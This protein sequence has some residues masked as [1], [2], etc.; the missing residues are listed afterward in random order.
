[1]NAVER[2]RERRYNYRSNRFRD[3]NSRAPSLSVF[4]SLGNLNHAINLMPIDGTSVIFRTSSCLA[5]LAFVL[6]HVPCAAVEFEY[7]RDDLFARHESHDVELASY[8]DDHRWLDR[9]SNG[10][11]PVTE[12]F[13]LGDRI[14]SLT[15]G[16]VQI[17][18]GYSFVSDT[19]A[20]SS[21]TQHT[22][23]DLLLRVGLTERL[24]VRVGW[25]GWVSTNYGGA[26][27]AS[28]STDTLEPNVGL[29]YDLWQQEGWLPQTAVLA[30]VPI[31]LEG[32]P[33]SMSGLQPLSQMLYSWCLT[34]RL[35]VGG[36]T[37]VALFRVS[38]DNFVQWQQSLN[39]DYLLT[40]RVGT[41]AEWEVL[42]DS[43][44]DDDGAAHLLGGGFSLLWTD[45]VQVSWRAGLGLNDRAPDFLTDIRFAYRF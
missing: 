12:R 27:S 25:P 24:E 36:A 10:G 3:P 13:A 16:R 18:G 23:P 9:E 5:A 45:S 41:F 19:I 8:T 33:F 31:T 43:G 38:G 6:I 21:A 4:H 14:T 17:E 32:S 29:M 39:L 28:S 1:M 42:I 26:L 20:G 15:R 7:D 30:A 22:V 34:D 35:S 11:P 2:H 37:G 40:D 44:S